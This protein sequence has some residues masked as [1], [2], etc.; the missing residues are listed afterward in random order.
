MPECYIGTDIVHIPR[1]RTI[2]QAPHSPRFLHRIYTPAEQ[3]YCQSKPDPAVHYAGRFAAKEAIKKCLM[4]SGFPDPIS[5]QSLEV[6]PHN[7]R[8]PQ[9]I[10][11]LEKVPTGT[12]RISISHDGEYAIAGA[13]FFPDSCDY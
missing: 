11:H 10:I 12:C 4:Q 13:I 1:I 3:T 9:V 2:L 7:R 6:L 5:F 8:G